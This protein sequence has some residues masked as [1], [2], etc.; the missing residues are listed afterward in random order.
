MRTI[1]AATLSLAG[2]ALF[3]AAPANASAK[4]TCSG[5]EYVCGGAPQTAKAKPAS[6]QYKPAKANKAVASY[7]A[8]Y[9]APSKPSSHSPQG[10]LS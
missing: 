6:S 3:A 8:S 4:W 9:D 2:V 1:I 5:P 7:D 10:W